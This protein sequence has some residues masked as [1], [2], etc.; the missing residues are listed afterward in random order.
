MGRRVKEVLPMTS[1]PAGRYGIDWNGTD[2]NGVRVAGGVYF[3]TLAAGGQRLVQR[4][5]LIAGDR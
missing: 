1:L 3:V 4:A 5:V 2:R